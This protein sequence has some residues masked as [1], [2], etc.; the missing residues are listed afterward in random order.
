MSQPGKLFKTLS[1]EHGFRH[2]DE[3]KLFFPRKSN[4]QS[5]KK[6][7]DQEEPLNLKRTQ[8]YRNCIDSII[9]EIIAADNKEEICRHLTHLMNANKDGIHWDAA[10]SLD[11]VQKLVFICEELPSGLLTAK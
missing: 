3:A 9:E 7:N 10:F 8:D 6:N 2:F 5:G 11:F 4:Q 1:G